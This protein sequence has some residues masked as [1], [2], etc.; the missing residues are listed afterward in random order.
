MTFKTRSEAENVSR[1]TAQRARP[2][3]HFSFIAVIMKYSS[4][5]LFSRQQTRAPSSRVAFSKFPGT[6]PRLPLSQPSQRRR[7]PKRRTR[8]YD[9]AHNQTFTLQLKQRRYHHKP[10][11]QL[12][13]ILTQQKIG[14]RSKLCKTGEL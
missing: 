7:R 10:Y 1:T 6:N 5:L 11:L 3:F 12:D 8:R 14:S 4:P 9:A 13:N 2:C